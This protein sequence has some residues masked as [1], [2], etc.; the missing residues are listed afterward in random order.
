LQYLADSAGSANNVEQRILLANPILEA[1]GNA[2]TVRNNNSS[3]FGKYIEIQF[4]QKYQI[5]GAQ[6][7]NYLLEK[8]RVVS[9]APNERNYHIFYQLILGADANQRKAFG[10]DKN[11]PLDYGFLSASENYQIPG[12]DDVSDFNDVQQS[13]Q[14]LNVDEKEMSNIF[15]IT[16]TVL[17]LGNIKFE[18]TG[19]RQCKVTT[20]NSLTWAAK[21]LQVSEAV[22]EKSMT[23][24]TFRTQRKG[25]EPKQITLSAKEAG[26]SRD[27]LAKHLYAKLFDWLVQRINGAIAESSTKVK[28]EVHSIGVLDIFGFEIFQVNSFE[29]LCINYTNEKLQ[30][31]FNANTFKLEEELYR[32]EAVN[33]TPVPYADNQPVLDL[34]EKKP[35]GILPTLDEVARFPGS[36]DKTFIDRMHKDHAN[37][38]LYAIPLKNPVNFLIRHYA[39]DVEYDSQGFLEKN[40]DTLLEDLVSLLGT[41]SFSFISEILG[42]EEKTSKKSLGLQFSQQLNNLMATLNAT[43]PHYIRCIKPNKNKTPQEFNG[44]MILEQLTNAGVFEAVQIRKSG[45]PFRYTHGDFCRRYKAISPQLKT[46]KDPKAGAVQLLKLMKMDLTQV[47]IGKTRVLYK[48]E[49]HRAMELRRFVAL[50]SVAVVVQKFVRGWQTRKALK[51]WKLK[52]KLVVDAIAQRSLEALTKALD[53]VANIRLPLQELEQ[54][55]RMKYILER[56]KA[57]TEQLKKVNAKDPEQFFQE[58]QAA[59]EAADDIDMDTPLANEVR[60]KHEYVKKKKLC[61]AQ[62]E[63]GIANVDEAALE[64]GLA[65]AAEIDL[66]VQMVTQAQEMYD[67]IQQEKQIIAELSS[68]TRDPNSGANLERAVQDAESFGMVTEEGIKL[69]QLG[70]ALVN[71]RGLLEQTG[72]QYDRRLWSPIEQ[73]LVE[74]DVSIGSHPEFKEAKAQLAF[75]IA[76]EEIINRLEEALSQVDENK[77]NVNLEAAQGYGLNPENNATVA[78]ALEKLDEIAN[79]KSQLYAAIDSMDEVALFDAIGYAES[80]YYNSNVVDE[81]RDVLARVQDFK[82]RVKQA[83]DTQ[84]VPAMK[85]VLDEAINFPFRLPELDRIEQLLRDPTDA[86]FS[87]QLLKSAVANQDFDAFKESL[88]G[89]KRML[90]ARNQKFLFRFRD[91]P[92]LKKPDVWAREKIT[93]DRDALAKSFYGHTNNVIHTSL[94]A[95]LQDNTNKQA[96]SLFKNV[97]A[98]MGDRPNTSDWKILIVELITRG[99]RSDQLRNEVFAQIVKQLTDNP[100][101]I[102]VE[103]GWKLMSLVLDQMP[104]TAIMADYLEQFLFEYAPN[105]D[106]FLQL[107]FQTLTLGGRENLPPVEMKEVADGKSIR[108]FGP[109]APKIDKSKV[110]IEEKSILSPPPSR[111]PPPARGNAPTGPPSR[112]PEPGPPSRGPRPTNAPRGGPP[113]GRAPSA[114]MQSMDFSS[115]LAE[116]RKTLPPPP[117]TPLSVSAPDISVP[118]R[119]APPSQP[120]MR[121]SPGA[122]PPMPRNAPRGPGQ[123]GGARRGRAPPAPERDFEENELD[124]TGRLQEARKTLPP[125]PRPPGQGA[126]VPP[127]PFGQGSMDDVKS[128]RFK[129]MV[130]E[131][132]E[133]TVD[134]ARRESASVVWQQ[135]Q[136][137]DTRQIVSHKFS[138]RLFYSDSVRIVLV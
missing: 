44:P 35:N 24:K 135:V 112:A 105:V 138:T 5:A 69:F 70:Q 2:K 60:Q 134:R 55:K 26:G 104:C 8:V 63:Q 90:A 54:A 22:L 28:G 59:V 36:T 65:L 9:I 45:F 82:F 94:I 120:P 14:N 15:Q 97:L 29:Q 77:I 128:V 133:F 132:D 51:E 91:F 13:F 62:L 46:D 49:Q 57:V 48:A 110:V 122:M 21:L 34:I 126:S 107:F 114:T 118:R 30:Q 83:L 80:F 86:G 66:R 117:P 121:S 47:Q 3:R 108:V 71:L 31:H 85:A 40:L 111:G 33:F 32:S 37:D 11:N 68:L 74:V 25:S 6:N 88:Q 56:E 10:L 18:D 73:L 113:S 131:V 27:A 20:K 42:S 7:I 12:V 100:V 61:L 98:L 116:A 43:E 106:Y 58:Y 103:R 39:G 119:A 53:Q 127:A 137:P 87:L 19:D 23:S 123:S 75:V 41:S 52:R 99:K 124:L 84:N 50:G 102:S 17:H 92:L 136:D 4:D 115:T 130:E 79:C 64:S 16:S 125:P 72:G 78:A 89:R 67:R 109:Y 95:G 129:S 76:A 101:T 81:A 96:I 93:F 38:Q 1:F